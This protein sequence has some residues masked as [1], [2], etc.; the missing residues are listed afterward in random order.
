MRCDMLEAIAENIIKDQ[1][2]LLDGI[3]IS[4]EAGIEI[5][6]LKIRISEAEAKIKR[7]VRLAEELD[8]VSMEYINEELKALDYEKTAAEDELETVLD[9]DG[10]SFDG[11]KMI[12]L[13]DESGVEIK[14]RIVS[15]II[16]IIH[17]DGN[18]VD[19]YLN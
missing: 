3:K 16:D 6:S 13:F 2:N 12:R 18:D 11:Q 9:G 19:I 8:E 14:K 10:E 4:E 17:I 15:V 5:N 7:L 1:I